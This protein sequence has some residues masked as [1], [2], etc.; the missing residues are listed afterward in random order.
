M[1]K[2][3][4]DQLIVQVAIVAK[5]TAVGGCIIGGMVGRDMHH[6]M[7][8]HGA[9]CRSNRAWR[10]RR[11]M[12]IHAKRHAGACEQHQYKGAERQQQRTIAMSA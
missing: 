1:G 3:R 5:R 12:K 6:G 11:V 9:L 2:P 8:A 10:E 4:H 7:V